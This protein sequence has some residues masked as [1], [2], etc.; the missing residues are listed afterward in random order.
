M[1]RI[2]KELAWSVHVIYALVTHGLVYI[3]KRTPLAQLL[4][5]STMTK[6]GFFTSLQTNLTRCC[7]ILQT[8]LDALGVLEVF[9]PK[10]REDIRLI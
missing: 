5:L 2:R 4:R 8:K 3:R 7:T 9:V 10:L 1:F 6:T